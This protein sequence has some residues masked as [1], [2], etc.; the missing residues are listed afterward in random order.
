MSSNKGGGYWE[1]CFFLLLFLKPCRPHLRPDWCP[2]P[3]PDLPPHPATQLNKNDS[4]GDDGLQKCSTLRS[5]PS[6]TH[7]PTEAKVLPCGKD[8][9]APPPHRKAAM[10]LLSVNRVTGN[11]TTY[12]W[13]SYQTSSASFSLGFPA[14][15]PLHLP[16][17]PGYPKLQEPAWQPTA[18]LI[19]Q[20]LG[21]QS[22]TAWSPNYQPHRS[23]Y[24][25]A[26]VVP[27]NPTCPRKSWNEEYGNIN[28]E[29]SVRKKM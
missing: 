21:T 6:L 8:T 12:L 13:L 24:V 26:E 4:R 10:P 23:H 15:L 14:S 2:I 19:L 7:Q 3:P 20:L 29:D 17:L 11:S 1:S 22:C 9:P 28:E 18:Q 16:V 27:W 25:T 5:E